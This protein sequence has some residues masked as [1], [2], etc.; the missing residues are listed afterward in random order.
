MVSELKLFKRMES[1]VGNG[2]Q[3]TKQDLEKVVLENLK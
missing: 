3:K 1:L 2:S